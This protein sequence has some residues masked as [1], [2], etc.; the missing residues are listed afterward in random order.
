[1]YG[2]NFKDL[3]DMP[4][5]KELIFLAIPVYHYRN[6]DRLQFL[7]LEPGQLVFQVENRAV[8]IW[9]LDTGK[10]ASW[11]DMQMNWENGTL[12]SWEYM[13]AEFEK[14][15]RA[16]EDSSVDAKAHFA[17]AWRR[18]QAIGVRI[19]VTFGWAEVV[20]QKRSWA[21]N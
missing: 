19:K 1:M 11:E 15:L 4:P 13:K 6:G 7:N 21:L 18:Q 16:M 12:V 20:D 3:R 8:N 2:D 14:K 10:F 5:M 9:P 17:D